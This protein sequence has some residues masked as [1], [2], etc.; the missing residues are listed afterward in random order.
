MGGKKHVKWSERRSSSLEA[1]MRQSNLE[2]SLDVS[3]SQT[4]SHCEE[5]LLR[6]KENSDGQWGKLKF[7]S[8]LESVVPLLAG[9]HP[10][11]STPLLH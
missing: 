1:K 8:V 6:L 9:V 5:E 10:E 11:V 2:G 7:S 3:H 4:R